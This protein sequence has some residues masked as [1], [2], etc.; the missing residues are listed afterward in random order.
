MKKKWDC[1]LH[2]NFHKSSIVYL[3]MV[4]QSITVI[5][6]TPQASF[7]INEIMCGLARVI[8]LAIVK[9]VGIIGKWLWKGSVATYKSNSPI[10]NFFD[11]LLKNHAL[12][13]PNTTAIFQNGVNMS[14]ICRLFYILRTLLKVS[15][16]ETKSSMVGDE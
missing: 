6:D 2:R 1:L 3:V 11:F 14:F 4:W 16:Q 15:S 10:L 8:K 5:C 7:W 12:G 13:I 9:L